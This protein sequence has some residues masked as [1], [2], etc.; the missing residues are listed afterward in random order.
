MKNKVLMALS[1]GIAA[2][3]APSVSAAAADQPVDGPINVPLNETTS[4]AAAT[5]EAEASTQKTEEVTVYNDVAGGEDIT[6]VYS[7]VNRE[8]KT[9]EG[10]NKTW[11]YSDM[12]S[13]YNEGIENIDD[14][15]DEVAPLVNDGYSVVSDREN[16]SHV[17]GTVTDEESQITNST[18][19]K[20][21][22]VNLVDDENKVLGSVNEESIISSVAADDLNK[23]EKDAF[24]ESHKGE[25]VEVTEVKEICSA[26][27]VNEAIELVKE[28]LN[29]NDSSDISVVVKDAADADAI[30]E[31]LEEGI[32]VVVYD[33]AKQKISGKIQLTEDGG[34]VVFVHEDGSEDQVV[35][36]DENEDGTTIIINGISYSIELDSSKEDGS[37]RDAEEK[38]NFRNKLYSG[39]ALENIIGSKLDFAGIDVA[40][41]RYNVEAQKVD[42]VSYSYYALLEEKYYG[43]VKEDLTWEDSLSMTHVARTYGQLA[44]NSKE[45]GEG[46]HFGY[47]TSDNK[48]TWRDPSNFTNN[49]G[50]VDIPDDM[51]EAYVNYIKNFTVDTKD[52]EGNADS[53]EVKTTYADV[54]RNRNYTDGRG[55]ST[56]NAINDEEVENASMPVYYWELISTTDG[57]GNEKLVA[58]IGPKGDKI[59]ITPEIVEGAKAVKFDE[60]EDGKFYFL[61][62]TLKHHGDGFHIDG[63]LVHITKE[64]DETIVDEIN[65]DEDIVE[66]DDETPDDPETPED[67]S[68]PDTPATPETPS[69]PG[70]LSTSGTPAFRTSSSPETP[71]APV[72][73]ISEE[74]TPLA[75]TPDDMPLVL[76]AQRA[77][78]GAVLGARRAK[79]GDES[80]ASTRAAAMAS[81]AAA[82]SMLGISST[83]HN[84]K[85]K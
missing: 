64:G 22:T 4:D 79:T 60:L 75:E 85:R 5:K 66:I 53:I 81:A 42:S 55:I 10:E 62:Y 21:Q 7:D 78:E 38:I 18:I 84:K 59:V 48:V 83:K 47:D 52:S 51:F 72:V 24:V 49:I 57:E 41:T 35:F 58:D 19:L 33:D 2:M 76:G 68:T 37:E 74:E 28:L 69:T 46:N 67:P 56:G 77:R 73:T 11:V 27:D 6:R 30:K 31:S 23:E 29:D 12:T 13:K 82:I 45:I 3:L 44:D 8:N 70:T 17:I 34:G 71:S 50:N 63:V 80:N 40:T 61:G 20:N 36:D 15:V 16:A 9:E 25:T 32:D 65:V 1:V 43:V 26:G 14:L 54:V 39:N